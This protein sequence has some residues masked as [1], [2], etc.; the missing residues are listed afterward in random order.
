[1]VKRS[2]TKRPAGKPAPHKRPAESRSHNMRRAETLPAPAAGRVITSEAQRWL[3]ATTVD[4]TPQKAGSILSGALVGDAAAQNEAFDQILDLCAVIRTEYE[5]RLNS[6][7]GLQPEIVTAEEA[8]QMGDDDPRG[9]EIRDYCRKT[10]MGMPAFHAALKHLAEGLGRGAAVVELVWS[11]RGRDQTLIDLTPVPFARLTGDPEINSRVR[12]SMPFTAEHGGW[13]GIALDDPQYAHKFACHAPHALSGT[14]FR[15]ALLRP[16]TVLF[17]HLFNTEAF[18]LIYAEVVGHPVRYAT[19]KPNTEQHKIDEMQ[20]LLQELG[21]SGSAVFPEGT[22]LT[23]VERKPGNEQIFAGLYQRFLDNLT[24]L[25]RG[26]TLTAEIGKTGGA[27]AASQTHAD[28]RGDLLTADIKAEAETVRRDILTPL[29]RLRFGEDAPVPYFRR[30]VEKPRD[31]EADGRVISLAVNELGLQVKTGWAAE[32]LGVEL[33]EGADPDAPLPGRS[34]AISPFDTIVADDGT[35]LS[36][37]EKKLKALS[38]GRMDAV[39]TRRS[40]LRPIAQWLIVAVSAS[41]AYSDAVVEAAVRR[42]ETGGTEPRLETG[43]TRDFAWVGE[44]ID[45]LPIDDLTELIY[46]FTLATELH[47]RARVAERVHAHAA[48]R[49]SM[50]PNAGALS[51]SHGSQ[52]RGTRPV[53]L[54]AE[55]EFANLPFTEAIEALRDRLGLDPQTFEALSAEARS[56]AFRVA[57]VWSMAELADIHRELLRVIETGGGARELRLALP[58]MAIQR[59]WTG[60]NPWH[61]SLVMFQNFA[62]SHAAGQRRQM[63][64]AGISTWEFR[65]AGDSCPICQPVISQRFRMSDRKFWPPLHFGC[66]CYAEVVFDEELDDRGVTDSGGIAAEAFEAQRARPNGFKFDVDQYANLQ[67][68]NLSEFPAALR[69]A[70]EAYAKRAGWEIA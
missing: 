4:L 68:V 49:E 8:G 60:E 17:I 30:V 62:M 21:V 24:K 26:A 67:P 28:I 56:R 59:G 70:F 13:R 19:Y 35:A 14:P 9:E 64:D 31:L 53:T 18:W 15:G 7:T 61:A 48:Y 5:L 34:T 20:R 23:L 44:L 43:A 47:G 39:L 55:I 66:D 27:Y 33:V 63:V 29:V 38:R 57:G 12:I 6:M 46:Q 41:T 69:P 65:S 36:P 40:A 11:E 58:A 3:S 52:S 42:L 50:P 2:A 22:T 45:G 10:L 16:A 32:A 51:R 54:A 25:F 1:M 37:R